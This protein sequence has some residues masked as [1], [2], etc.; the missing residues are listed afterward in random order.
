MFKQELQYHWS[1]YLPSAHVGNNMHEGLAIVSRHPIISVQ[2]TR[3]PF[4][5]NDQDMN[6]RV[7]LVV[8]IDHPSVGSVHVGVTHLSYDLSMQCRNAFDLARYIATIRTRGERFILLGD[9]NVY[10]EY[11]GVLG[12]LVD[13]PLGH[14][15]DVGGRRVLVCFVYH[16]IHALITFDPEFKHAHLRFKVACDRIDLAT[17]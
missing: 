1:A 4:E 7:A 9:F 10:A 8:E 5:L 15:A 17:H 14:C 2:H 11:E 13:G 16:R 6:P 3:L 12:P